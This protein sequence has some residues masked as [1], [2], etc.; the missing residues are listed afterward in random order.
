VLKLLTTLHHIISYIY[1]SQAK[2]R[3]NPLIKCVSRHLCGIYTKSYVRNV[4]S[5]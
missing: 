2:M 5:E 4:V 1:I 3:C